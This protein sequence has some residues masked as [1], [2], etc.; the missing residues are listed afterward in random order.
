M[1]KVS[2]YSNIQLKSIAWAYYIEQKN[3]IPRGVLDRNTYQSTYKTFVEK[4]TSEKRGCE[5]LD[6]EL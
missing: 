4:Q 2:S 1:R 3:Q 6:I 5:E